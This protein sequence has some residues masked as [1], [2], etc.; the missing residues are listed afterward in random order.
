MAAIAGNVT[1]ENNLTLMQAQLRRVGIR[2]RPRLLANLYAPDGPL[3]TGRYQIAEVAY[4]A[5]ADPSVTNI[6]RSDQVPSAANG[7]SGQN[8]FRYADPQ[9]DSLLNASD[10]TVDLSERARLLR[11]AQALIA[12][13][14]PEIPLYTVTRLDAVPARLQHFKGNPTNT[15]IFWNIHEWEMK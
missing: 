14:V 4:S 6:F 1:R 13:A 12:D 10:R 11:R 9:L 3:F 15:G 2:M 8:T 5:S 7:F